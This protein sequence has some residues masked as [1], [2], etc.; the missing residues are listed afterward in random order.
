MLLAE[1]VARRRDFAIRLALGASP[2]ALGLEATTEGLLLS[3]PA[4]AAAIL[5]S[6]VIAPRIG[7]ALWTGSSPLT[8]SLTP[9][10]IVAAAAVLVAVAAS[11]L[12]AAVPVWLVARGRRTGLG[13]ARVAERT[14]YGA[15]GALIVVQVAIAFALVC[16]AGAFLKSLGLGILR[17]ELMHYA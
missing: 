4:S 10:A 7:A 5:A 8:V 14:R 6:A 11:V 2:R 1:A 3:L 15:Q 12:C 9:D 17:L 16:C 13:S